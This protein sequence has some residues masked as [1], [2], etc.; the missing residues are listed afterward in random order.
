MKKTEYKIVYGRSSED[1]E[2]EVNAL[3]A[4]GWITDGG[5]A[6]NSYNGMYQAMLRQVPVEGFDQKE[7]GL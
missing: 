3:I 1:L 7:H 6:I 5:V 2:Q 4:Q